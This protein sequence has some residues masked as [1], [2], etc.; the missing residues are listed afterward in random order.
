MGSEY[1][2]LLKLFD[3]AVTLKYNQDHWKWYE[4]VKL[5]EY[6]HRTKSDIYHIYSVQENYVKSFCHIWTISQPNTDQ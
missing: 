4:W 2:V 1:T 6:Y 5:S 3:T